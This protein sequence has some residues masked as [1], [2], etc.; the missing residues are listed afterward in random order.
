MQQTPLLGD[1]NT[2][3]HVTDGGTGF[4]GATPRHQVAFTPNPL[5]TP[6]QRSGALAS[7]TPRSE[8]FGSTPPDPTENCYYSEGRASNGASNYGT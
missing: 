2:P 3:L 1:E 8:A 7:A 6:T 5:A 4:E